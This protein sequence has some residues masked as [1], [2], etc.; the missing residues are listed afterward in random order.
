MEVIE[1]DT[2]GTGIPIA[3]GE[4][5]ECGSGDGDSGEGC[6]TNTVP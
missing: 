3:S 2:V 4:G 5:Y 1:L 6:W